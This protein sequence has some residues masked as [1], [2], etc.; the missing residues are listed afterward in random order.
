M[1]E[2][3]ASLLN[4]LTHYGYLAI[5]GFL[6][7]GIIALPFPQETLLILAG[8]LM[9]DGKL[10]IPST[11]ISAYA[12]CV[13]GITINYL[14]GLSIG[15]YLLLRF[16][17]W[18]GL[19]KDDLLQAKSWFRHFGTWTLF[20]GYFIPGVRHLTGLFAGMLRLEYPIFALFSYAG[21]LLW[22]ALFLSIG[23]F[24]GNYWNN[25]FEDI[26]TKTGLIIFISIVAYVTYLIIKT[27]KR[28]KK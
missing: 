25:M 9:F 15:K 4:W 21:A 28:N 1:E 14:L 8:I 3:P 6:A 7:L 12:G 27:V 17:S 5:F 22:V 16:G 18:V 26:E 10:N 11:I 2:L 19:T 24:F 20:F 23:Y 13:C